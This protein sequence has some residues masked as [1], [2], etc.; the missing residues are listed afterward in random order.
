VDFITPPAAYVHDRVGGGRR[1]LLVST[2]HKVV[3]IAAR[4]HHQMLDANA[5]DAFRGRRVSG[6]RRKSRDC[7]TSRSPAVTDRMP[8]PVRRQACVR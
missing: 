3:E 2:F 4:T 8:W 1:H 6:V 7:G 5:S